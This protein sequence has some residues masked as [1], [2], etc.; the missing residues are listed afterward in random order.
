MIL[1]HLK[2]HK[3]LLEYIAKR[4]LEKETM[5]GKEFEDIIKA[6]NHCEELIASDAG[7]KASGSSTEV[8]STEVTSTEVATTGAKPADDA[9]DSASKDEKKPAKKTTRRAKKDKE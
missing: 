2:K 5:E 8:T 1:Y 3:N 9:K 6:E 4:L 7:K